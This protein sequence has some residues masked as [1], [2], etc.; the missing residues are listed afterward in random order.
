MTADR[1]LKASYG[2]TRT[3]TTRTY[4]PT[5]YRTTYVP[6]STVTRY[7]GGVYGYGGSNFVAVVGT[8]GMYRYYGGGFFMYPHY[9]MSSF[10]IISSILICFFFCG[11]CFVAYHLCYNCAYGSPARVSE[12]E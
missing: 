12:V 10:S 4:V 3:T 5:T 6:T 8:P 11:C 9:G 1:E 7:G 2:G